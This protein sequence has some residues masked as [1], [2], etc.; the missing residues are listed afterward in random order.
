MSEIVEFLKARLGADE[1]GAFGLA[2]ECSG[3]EVRDT[4]RVKRRRI[5]DDVPI[6]Q[7]GRGS[8]PI[9]AA[10]DLRTAEHI[11]RHDP[12]RVLREVEAKRRIVHEYEVE[13][14]RGPAGSRLE[15][16]ARHGGILDAYR[17]SLRILASAYADHPDYR[18]EWAL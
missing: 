1:A 5:T 13:V 10:S 6:H 15:F 14:D 11:A 18:Q 9:A 2:A 17:A 4:E 8:G 7:R 12:V 3:W 16:E